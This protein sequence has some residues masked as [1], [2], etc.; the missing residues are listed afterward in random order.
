MK[1]A[2]TSDFKDILAI[3]PAR[4]GS[5]RFPGKPL[6]LIHG[7][8]M[9]IRVY[10]ESAKVFNHTVIATDDERIRQA[11]E[12][13][14]ASCIMTTSVH[15]SGTSRCAEA[16]EI[17]RKNTGDHFKAVVNI[18]GD[19]PL[20]SK[21]ALVTLAEAVQAEDA[22]IA[23][24]I[25]RETNLEEITNPNRVK[26]VCDLAG[27][28][29]Y[30]SRSPIPYFVESGSKGLEHRFYVHIGVYGFK[31]KILREIQALSPGVLDQAESLEQLRW[32]ESGYRIACRET[33][34]RGF[35]I[36]TPE[37]LDQLV[38]LGLA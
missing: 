11:A 8:P 18:Q 34:Y 35:G 30:F 32:L 2:N 22:G 1:S 27:L 6:A 31:S 23:T 16:A 7:I 33:Q 24:L 19:E 36:D 14:N 3:I 20:I 5:S 21:E 15:A 17:F 12:A 29:L 38:R 10:Q 4:W 26:V 9:V 37:D 25:R 28:A 13:F